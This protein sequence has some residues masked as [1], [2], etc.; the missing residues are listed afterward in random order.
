MLF[1]CLSENILPFF[2]FLAATKKLGAK[3]LKGLHSVQPFYLCISVCVFFPLFLWSVYVKYWQKG[4]NT[5]KCTYILFI[6]SWQTVYSI[7]QF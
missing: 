7:E 1:D 2:F 3:N 4:V 5:E 6:N